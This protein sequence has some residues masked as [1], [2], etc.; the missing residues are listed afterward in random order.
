[1]MPDRGM[2]AADFQPAV[3]AGYALGV[4]NRLA[5]RRVE[6]TVSQGERT[7]R[8]ALAPGVPF[9]AGHWLAL[10]AEAGRFWLGLTSAALDALVQPVVGAV[11]FRELDETLGEAVVAMALSQWLEQVE[12]FQGCTFELE[13]A[14]ASEPGKDLPRFG[15][16]C[17]EETGRC[18]WGVV[19]AD[20]RACRWMA[21]RLDLLPAPGWNGK[22]A[23]LPL[24]LSLVLA[25][26]S[27]A[28]RELTTLAPGDILLPPL[29][30]PFRLR[31][32]NAVDGLGLGMARL[33]D[34]SLIVEHWLEQL[35]TE[36]AQEDQPP[37][38]ALENLEVALHFELGRLQLP[39]ARLRELGA[40]TVLPLDGDIRQ[41]VSIHVNR[42]LAG[43]GEI[44]RIDERL[45]I[46]ITEWLGS[47]LP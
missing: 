40:G 33:D 7:I 47:E 29:Q 16:Y 19:V 30:E 38:T 32:E 18:Q 10:E 4:I 34:R 13:S 37:L 20:A 28:Q 36:Q 35:M 11:R 14:S 46:R 41:P 1:M 23:G 12:V 22:W 3:V 42:Q 2:E 27:L 25:R 31:L 5:G 6:A 44:V 24:F 21:A 9:A 8:L 39:L 26:M 45:G 15:L 43:R 17:H